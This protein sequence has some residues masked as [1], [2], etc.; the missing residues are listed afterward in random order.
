MKKRVGTILLAMFIVLVLGVNGVSAVNV[1]PDQVVNASENVNSYINTNH[2][3][4]SNTSVGGNQVDMPQYLKLSTGAVLN[5]NAGSSASI[6][7]ESYSPAPSPSETITP[8]TMDKTGYLELASR[9]QSFM[10]TNGRAPN[11]AT[12]SAGNIRYESLIYMYSGILNSYRIN[13]VL[14]DYVTV[15]PWTSVL[16][17][18]VIGSTSYGYVEKKFYGNQSSSQTVA[19]IIGVHPQENGI[20]SAIFNA[21]TSKSLD[22]TK[23]YVLYQV[24]VTQDA[25]DYSKGRMNGQLLAQAFVVPDIASENPF[26]VFDTHENHGADSGYSYYRFLYLISNNDD[27]TNYANQIISQIPSLAI[28]T[29]PNPTSTQYVTV[30]IANQGLNTI[31]YETYFYDSVSQKTSDADALIEAVDSL[32]D[33]SITPIN[34]SITGDQDTG[35]Y[36][37]LTN[38][39]P[40]LFTIYYTTDGSDPETS[41]TRTE[42][43]TPLLFTLNTLLK[44]S[45][46]DING[47]WYPIFNDTIT[48]DHEAPLVTVVT[49]GGTYYAP[50]NV[51]L[52]ATDDQDPNPIIYYTTDGSNPR[53]S[54]TRKQYTAPINVSSSL[55]LNFYALD[56]SGQESAVSTQQYRIYKTVSYSYTVD[57]AYKK[58]WYKY[59]YKVSY[60]KWYKSWYKYRG[61]WRYK[62]KYK[63]AQKSK[64][65][66][67]YGWIY[68]KETRW[69]TKNVLT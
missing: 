4:P 58:G 26:L 18:D 45:M 66:W 40:D 67:K 1:T 6:P 19:L 39:Y 46:V 22:L 48:P 68:R 61:K 34:I 64:Y 42:Y 20:H 47:N 55:T 27:T 50:Q 35:W 14:P 3:L 63:W 24:T 36:L 59:W 29:P 32:I 7:I 54:S 53:T 15:D 41:S 60:K 38:N 51:V 16:N 49:A 13:N 8:T 65:K 31:L 9:V 10:D 69:G 43:T 21:M 28:Y 56:G 17:S 33:P 2:T 37:T 62:W 11:Y 52:A 30:P 5:I 23:R 44:I 57:V 12:T 25:D